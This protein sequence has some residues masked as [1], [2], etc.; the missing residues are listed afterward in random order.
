[1]ADITLKYLT[2]LPSASDAESSNLMHINQAGNDRSI[3]L[4]VLVSAIFNIRYPVGKVEWFANDTNPN[5]IWS[6]STWAR[7]PGQGKTIRIANNT[8]SDVMQQGGADEVIISTANMPMHQHDVNVQTSS[9]DYGEKSTKADGSH[10]HDST[11]RVNGATTNTTI[12]DV[13]KIGSG[14]T[15]TTSTNGSHSHQI[16]IGAHKHDVNGKTEQTGN[17]EALNITNAYIKL[18]AWYRVA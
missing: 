2:D 17:G 9:Y 7:M 15:K 14:A 16:A 18:A 1:M 3:T 10:S 11:F 8:G 12:D 5:A 13:Y 4:D 6:G